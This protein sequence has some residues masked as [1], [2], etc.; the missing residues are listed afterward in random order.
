MLEVGIRGPGAHCLG[1]RRTGI[2][3]AGS[4]GGRRSQNKNTKNHCISHV[5]ENVPKRRNRVFLGMESTSNVC[6]KAT[7]VGAG[8]V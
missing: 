4:C 6:P 1:L 3:V 7:A 8:A 2:G 5:G